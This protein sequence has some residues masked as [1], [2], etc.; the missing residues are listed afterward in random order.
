MKTDKTQKGGSMKRYRKIMSVLHRNGLEFLFAKTVISRNPQKTL[1]KKSR[2]PDQPAVAERVRR[3]CEQLGPAFVKLGQIMS[4]RTDIIPAEVAEELRKLQ[5]DVPAFSF[6]EAREVIESELGGKIEDIFT[7]FEPVP[8]AA[9]SVSQV[10]AAHLASGA[11]VAVKVQRPGVMDIIE[12]DLDILKKLA[13]LVDRHTKYGKLYDFENMVTQIRKVMEQEMDF[14]HEGK[15]IDHFRE[16]FS[17]QPHVKVPK[18]KW[19]YT[20]RKVLTMDYAEGVKIDDADGLDRINADR[21]FI[22]KVFMGSLLRQILIHGFFHADPHHANVLVQPDGRG[23]EF[24]DLGM[25]GELSERFR[26]QLSELMLGVATRNA[27]KIARAIISMDENNAEPDL[28]MLTRSLSAMLDEYLYVP[29]HKVKIAKF[30]SSVFLLAADFKMKIAKE[31]ALVTKCLGT[32]QGIMEEL[33]PTASILDVAD[34]TVNEIIKNSFDSQNIKQ[35]LTSAFTDSTEIIKRL[36]S[37]LLR[38]ME[39]A[40]DDDFRIDMNIRHLEKMDKNLER[41]ANRVSF[42]I[43]LLAI[44]ILIAGVT[45]ALGFQSRY[46]D[47]LAEFSVFALGAGLVIAAVIVVGLILNIIY[48]GIRKK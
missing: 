47:M 25:A 31:F 22:G 12:T 14:I 37:F 34:E 7:A 48:T 40:E 19:V 15:N 10:Y 13:R 33:D 17:D 36:P 45:I 42:T 30:F 35:Y 2:T 4:A 28:R 6:D 8:I 3:A 9:A 43:V 23:I 11:K 27:G 38:F 26:R 21:K 44:C 29:V 5:D 32:A 16:N 39:K 1:N 24:I 41:V 20:T 18:V 46:S